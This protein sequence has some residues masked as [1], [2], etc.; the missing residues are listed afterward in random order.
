[1]VNATALTIN[2]AI[3]QQETGEEIKPPLPLR[4]NVALSCPAGR[5][6]YYPSSP[7]RVSIPLGRLVSDRLHTHHT[8]A[9][10]CTCMCA[11]LLELMKIQPHPGMS[12]G[13][14][15]GVTGGLARVRQITGRPRTRRTAPWQRHTHTLTHAN[16]HKKKTE[17]TLNLLQSGAHF[18]RCNCL[19]GH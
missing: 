18:K 8:H 1:M 2:T 15:N 5:R 3:Y 11:C 10:E 19:P 7:P 16:T 4:G 13:P 14:N 12:N 6:G 9:S 17:K